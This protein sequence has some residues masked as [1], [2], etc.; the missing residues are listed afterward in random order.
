MRPRDPETLTGRAVFPVGTSDSERKPK[1]RRFPYIILP[2]DMP[3]EGI[4]EGSLYMETLVF[5]LSPYP[6]E[7][8]LTDYCGTKGL[9]SSKFRCHPVVFAK[10]MRQQGRGTISIH[11]NGDRFHGRIN[12]RP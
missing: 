4:P 8:V 7:K 5:S 12:W 6:A 11:R 2:L 9:D 1:V 10:D 3:K